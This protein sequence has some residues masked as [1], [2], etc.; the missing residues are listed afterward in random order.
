MVCTN[1]FITNKLLNIKVNSL[2]VIDSPFV[3]VNKFELLKNPD[4]L[5]AP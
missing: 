3:D 4:A 1:D 5:I 2:P